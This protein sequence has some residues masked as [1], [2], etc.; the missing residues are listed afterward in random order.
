MDLERSLPCSQGPAPGPMLSQTHLV[1]IFLPYFP[2]I[3]SNFIFTSTPTSSTRSLPFMFS[4]LLT[5][6]C[7][8][9]RSSHPPWFDHLKNVW[10]SIQVVKLLII[11]YSPASHPFSPLTSKYSPQHPVLKHPQ[12]TRVYPK[13]SGLAAWSENCN[14]YSSLPLDAVVSLFCESV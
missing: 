2:N 5:H 8:M 1:H 14:W 3:H 11:Q 9:P 4:D 10:C 6:A 13:V 7:F 12:S